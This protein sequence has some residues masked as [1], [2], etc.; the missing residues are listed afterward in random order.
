MPRVL[1]EQDPNSH[2]ATARHNVP[3]RLDEHREGCTSAIKTRTA[4][5]R[6]IRHAQS[7]E[8]VARARGRFS[9][10]TAPT[11]KYMKIENFKN[12]VLSRFQILFVEV[13]KVLRLPR[14]MNPRHPKCCTCHVKSSKTCSTTVS[15]TAIF[16]PFK[17]LS[18]FTAPVTKNEL[19]THL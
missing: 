6:A 12:D 10:N 2:H 3:R 4:P 13:Y 17:T 16:D 15:Q 18:K 19:Q 9:Q 14:K 11:T 1:R 8:R 7:A 5:R